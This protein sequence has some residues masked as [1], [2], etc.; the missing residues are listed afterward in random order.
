MDGETVV[1]GDFGLSKLAKEV[2]N[3]YVGT[4]THMAPEIL[5]I[6][7]RCYYTTTVDLWSIGITFYEML[8]GKIPWNNIRSISDIKAEIERFSG[9]N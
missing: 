8:F 2:T 5:D 7:K 9:D 3:T 1:I 6:D 4:P